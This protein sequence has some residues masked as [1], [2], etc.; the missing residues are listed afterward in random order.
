VDDIR[1]GRVVRML[2]RRRRWTQLALASRAGVSQSTVSLIERGQ[3]EAVGLTA[4]RRAL[5]VLEA[6]AEIGL[7]WRG[8]ELDRLLDQGHAAL[9]SATLTRLGASGWQGSTEVT[10]SI[11][12]ERGSID[13]LAWRPLERALLVVEVKSEITAAEATLRKHDEKVRL[14]RQIVA[15]RFGWQPLT[16]SRLL[17]LP[18]SRTS[19]RRIAAAHGLLAA[20]YP[21]HGMAL[22]AWLRRPVGEVEALLYLAN[23]DVATGSRRV[24][25]RRQEKPESRVEG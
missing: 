12:G 1:V 23:S 2:R 14:A 11:Y 7:R 21:V 18:E 20:S 15:E 6:Q 5:R 13:V 19:R 3:V 25:P 8:G 24:R 9:V 17:V 22:R 10:Y 16:V 4:L